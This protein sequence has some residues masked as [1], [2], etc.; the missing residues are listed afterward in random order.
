MNTA[1]AMYREVGNNETE[2]LYYKNFEKIPADEVKP[3]KYLYSVSGQWGSAE[4]PLHQ[5]RMRLGK[6]PY[7]CEVKLN[8]TD[9]DDVHII[10]QRTGNL[11]HIVESGK[12][13]I[14]S[15]NGVPARQGAFSQGDVAVI[16][17]GEDTV[18][19]STKLPEKQNDNGHALKVDESLGEGEYGLLYNNSFIRS[20]YKQLTLIG[21]N[22]LCDISVPG[23][24]FAA[25][26][27]NVGRKMYITNLGRGENSSLESDGITVADRAPLVPGSCIKINNSEILF[28]LSKDMRF[29]KTIPE[30]SSASNSDQMCLLLLNS[31][32]VNS[33]RY[34]L[35]KEGTSFTIGRDQR[36][37]NIAITGSLNI[38][39]VHCQVIMYKK[40]MMLIDNSSTNGSFVNGEKIKRT[41][42]KPGD[43][44][45][46][47]DSSFILCFCD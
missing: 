15:I 12:N 28:K 37:A 33:D 20:T 19:F 45:R 31:E 5:S 16:Q 7:E 22:P 3:L 24:P 40:R 36:V 46:L 2:I 11:W 25:M 29:T 38:S 4:L 9:A 17:V 26:I 30:D 42:V 1:T 39:R 47:G 18:I 41:M 43:I 34:T 21:S 13:E 35:M 23:E 8:H 10:L 27:S 6:N 32:G 44:I 14:M